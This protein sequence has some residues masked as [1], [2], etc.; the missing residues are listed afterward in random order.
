MEKYYIKDL[1]CYD[2]LEGSGVIEQSIEMQLVTEKDGNLYTTKE[3]FDFLEG[4][5]KKFAE[6]ENRIEKY[7]DTNNIYAGLIMW[8]SQNKV[9]NF[10]VINRL[11][12]EW[13]DMTDDKFE[14]QIKIWKRMGET[15]N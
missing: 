11:M 5:G 12:E 6:F 14:T 2:T 10:I 15:N 4:C 1:K 13:L 7:P 9:D 8:L 3:N